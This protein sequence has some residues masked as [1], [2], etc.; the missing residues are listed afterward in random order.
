M[1]AFLMP[2]ML[3]TASAEMPRY[4]DLPPDLA[5]AAEAFD[6]AQVKGDRAAL[7]RLLADD[8]LLVNSQGQS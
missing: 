6:K 1:I 4:P 5:A 8:Y 2:L 7:E 3:A